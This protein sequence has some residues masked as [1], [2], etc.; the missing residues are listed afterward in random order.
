MPSGPFS[1]FAPY[2]S[3]DVYFASY[4]YLTELEPFKS[5]PFGLCE[6]AQVSSP[7]KDSLMYESMMATEDDPD[8][9]E[10]RQNTTAKSCL[11]P[12]P[13]NDLPD[14]FF[15]RPSVI[16]R[17]IPQLEATLPSQEQFENAYGAAS[18]LVPARSAN[19]KDKGSDYYATPFDGLKITISNHKSP[20]INRD[21]G[22]SPTRY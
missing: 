2:N 17:N 8:R 15:C 9:G 21:R 20:S 6:V 13:S 18:D 7:E 19:N 3:D 16:Y 14:D 1:V 4:C 10:N 11:V 5:A 22:R 12:A